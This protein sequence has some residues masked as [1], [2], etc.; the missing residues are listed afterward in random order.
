[1]LHDV[2][3]IGTGP[4]AAACFDTIKEERPDLRLCMLEAGAEKH[5]FEYAA[6]TRPSS[7]FK[8]SPTHYLGFGGTSELWHSVMA[9]LDK[10][11]FEE[12]QEFGRSGWPFSI[13]ELVPYY[14]KAIKF[15][16]LPNYEIFDNDYVNTLTAHLDMGS[17]EELF[18]PKLFVQLK[19]R[20]KAVDY[21]KKVQPIIKFGHFV[22]AIEQT[23]N[24]VKVVSVDS[25]N[26]FN[27]PQY[28]RCAIICAGGLNSP[29]ILYNSDMDE[30]SRSNVGAALLDH[31][32]GVGLQ[33]KRPQKY[34]FEIL[35]SLKK[36]N[37][38]QKIAFR[39]KEQV[40]RREG[41]PNSSFFFRPSFSEGHSQSTEVLK[42]KLLTYRDYIKRRRLPVSL[43]LELLGNL[44]VIGQV[45]SYKT[46]FLSE[47]DLFDIFCVTEQVEKNSYIRFEKDKTGFYSGECVWSVGN[48][49]AQLTSSIL[50]MIVN[51]G[52]NSSPP[53]K[54]TSYPNPE[55][56]KLLS[57]SA[58]H[59][60]GTAPMAALAEN[61]VV[62]KQ[63]CVFGSG[64]RIFV[65]DASVMPSA[66][67]ANV[68]F[69]SIS[70][71]IKV[72]E[73]VSKTF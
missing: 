28:A 52:V 71:A 63:G 29:Q 18:E 22:R 49:D 25:K 8:L 47:V 4:S 13:N 40:Q 12:R 51:W 39:V 14:K 45:I 33:I 55:E 48:Y 68:T 70:L 43:T 44:D 20:W 30:A 16:N 35:T 26:R 60:I 38:N 27:L 72:G 23:A 66:G 17:F 62:D 5:S 32:M 11:D 24:G 73:Y 7:D 34:N 65:A 64:G 56:W 46:G 9:P 54:I 6:S 42:A 58:A 50:D 41:L 21:W 53:N 10:I 37:F 15:L 59:H 57:T 61:G 2:I 36:R 31:P 1:M 69:T 19:K 3:I 67:C